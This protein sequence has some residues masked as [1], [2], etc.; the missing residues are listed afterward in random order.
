MDIGSGFD[1]RGSERL[2]GA[3][4]NRSLP[5]AR[6]NSERSTYRFVCEDCVRANLVTSPIAMAGYGGR[7][8]IS[9][10]SRSPRQ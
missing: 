9:E 6:V 2:D 1:P 4:T 8:D 7:F 5:T 3:V 10:A